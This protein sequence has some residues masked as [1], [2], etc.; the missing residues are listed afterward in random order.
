M[1][2]CHSLNVKLSNSQLNKLKSSIKNEAGVA[3]RL[4]LNIVG[5]DENNF[6]HKS[7]LT[8]RQVEN[9][10][11][12]CTYFCIRFIDFMIAGKTLTDFTNLFS[13]NNFKKNDDMILNYFMINV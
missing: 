4:S 11:V 5:D 9:D 6:P 13:P 7:L 8:Y 1:T 10:I 12:T 2:Q 3:L